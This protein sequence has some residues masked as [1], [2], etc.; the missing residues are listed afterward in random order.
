MRLDDEVPLANGEAQE[1]AKGSAVG[2]RDGAV[3]VNRRRTARGNSAGGV[4]KAVVADADVDQTAP[5]FRHS[6]DRVREGTQSIGLI[7]GD[8]KEAGGKLSNGVSG[9]PQSVGA[10]GSEGRFVS[11]VPV[12]EKHIAYL[13]SLASAPAT[14]YRWRYR[15]MTPSPDHF[16]RDLWR[17]VL[18]QFVI[19]RNESKSPIGLIT[20]FGADLRNGY[21]YMAIVIDQKYARRVHAIEAAKLFNDYL[22]VNFPLRK[23]YAETPGWNVAQFGS[24]A[25]AR[26]R[27]EARLRTH[28]FFAGRYWD[29]HIFAY[30]RS[31]WEARQ[32]QRGVGRAAGIVMGVPAAPEG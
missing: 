20:A 1:V 22:F 11:L 32:S 21:A 18:C 15:G 10:V 24:G 8:S 5:L 2:D 17:G 14:S 30:Y 29:S 28:E 3:S 26:F 23:V 9:T 12:L 13:S 27:E 19:Q 4:A 31:D 7:G 6:P 16:V 25:E